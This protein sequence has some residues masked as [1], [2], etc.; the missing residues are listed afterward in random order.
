MLLIRT[1]NVRQY[2]YYAFEITFLSSRNFNFLP[3]SLLLSLSCRFQTFRQNANKLNVNIFHVKYLC[4]LSFTL[5]LIDTWN[6]TL[7]ASGL[8][9][10]CE[11]LSRSDGNSRSIAPADNVGWQVTLIGIPVYLF[12]SNEAMS[13]EQTCCRLLITLYQRLRVFKISSIIL[14]YRLSVE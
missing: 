1:L 11:S 9:V 5:L 3:L 10:V 4:S 8:V 6:W 12:T 2:H 13:F 14:I 7:L